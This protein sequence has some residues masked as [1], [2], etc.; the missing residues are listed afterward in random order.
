MK[1]KTVKIV[2]FNGTPSEPCGIAVPIILDADGFYK[3]MG[4]KRKSP[5]S[6][7]IFETYVKDGLITEIPPADAEENDAVLYVKESFK[8]YTSDLWME[9][10]EFTWDINFNSS[11]FSN[12][13]FNKVKNGD[14]CFKISSIENLQKQMNEL[15]LKLRS[16]F[17]K[18]WHEN[19]E[20]TNYLLD[21]GE[22]IVTCAR[23][24]SILREGYA[25]LGLTYEVSN[26]EDRIEVLHSLC[27]EPELGLTMDQTMS[28]I[29]K[30]K[31]LLDKSKPDSPVTSQPE[32]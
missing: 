26:Q 28:E 24:K 27:L 29:N 19:P 13:K 5:I 12:W 16:L 23:E 14:F 20:N 17:D 2:G 11:T 22:L 9:E 1:Q 30:L 15:A 31:Q 6:R 21:I 3:K 25:R 8:K 4:T 7:A 10:D 32:Y 18:K